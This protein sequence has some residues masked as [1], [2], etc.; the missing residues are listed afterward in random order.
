MRSVLHIVAS[1]LIVVGSALFGAGCGDD[2]EPEEHEEPLDA[3]C[4]WHPGDGDGD[5]D[6]DGGGDGDGDGDGDDERC[7]SDSAIP[8]D[9]DCV[10]PGEPCFERDRCATIEDEE[11][12][13]RISYDAGHDLEDGGH[14]NL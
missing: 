3:C 7:S 4:G 12:E 14:S 2:D 13:C 1:T 6:G 10:A 5:G 11:E 9:C 8:H